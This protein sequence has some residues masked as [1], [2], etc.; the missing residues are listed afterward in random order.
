MSTVREE[1]E[2]ARKHTPEFGGRTLW[3]EAGM[4]AFAIAATWLTLA[5]HIPLWAGMVANTVFIYGI[6]TVAHEAVHANISSRRKGLRWVDTV[7]GTLACAPLWLFYH[8]HRR[9][10]M[11]HHAHTNEASDPDLYA[12]GSFPVWIFVKLPAALIQYF[13]PVAQYREC[14]RFGC[15]KR[16]VVYT[17]VTFAIYSAALIGAVAAGYWK[18]VLLLWF[19]PWWVGQ[20]VMLTFFTWTPH[21]DHTETGRYRN[22]RVSLFPMGPVR[23]TSVGLHWQIDGLDFAPG[24]TIGTSNRVAAAQV[25]IKV[26]RP[27]MLVILPKTHLSAAVSALF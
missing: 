24:R 3:L 13:N 19:V 17:F 23:G 8:Q 7:A 14:R 2:I 25:H 15:P 21:H 26:D 9:Q 20:T 4:F 18:E 27:A 10:H 12:K 22:T 11:A 6:Y 1:F 5:G 16:K